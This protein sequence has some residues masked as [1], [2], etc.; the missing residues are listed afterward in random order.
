MNKIQYPQEVLDKM[1]DIVDHCMG[2]APA[3]CV[4]ECPMH[5]DVKSYVKL[6][7]E[8][9]TEEAL[10]VIREKL[11]LPG[12]LGRICAHPCEEKCKRGEQGEAMRIAALKRFA[13]DTCDGPAIWDMKKAPKNG[14]KVAVIGAGPAG[15]QS[16]LDL[17]KKGYE[18]TIYE[19]LP[20][21]GGMMHVGIPE[22]RL[23]RNVINNEYEYLTKLGVEIR[24]GV[25]IGKDISF[26]A[27][28]QS[29]D[30]VIVA[31]GAHIGNVL[32]IEG[33]KA[34]GVL[35]AVDFLREVALTRNY[36]GLGKR[37]VVIGGG[38]VAMD[39][40]RS[41]RRI[42]AEEVILTC[43]EG[44][45]E[46][47]PA[48]LW[49][50]EEAI[51]EG[52]DVRPGY[53]PVKV[54]EEDG[55][56]VGY[57]MKKCLSIFDEKGNF[58]PKYD[59]NDVQV[60]SVDNVCFAIGQG[61]DGSFAPELETQRGGRFVVDQV[62]LQTTKNPKVFVAGDASGRSVIVIEAM[63]EGRKAAESVDRYLNHKNMTEG[64]EE[65]GSYKTWLETE[66]PK[67]E[68]VAKCA[69][70][71]QLDP[72]ERVKSFVEV[73]L[74]LKE[75]DAKAEANRCLQ[76][77]C[78][79][80]MKECTMLNEYCHC[81]KDLFKGILERTEENP[82]VPYSCN[83]C[84]QCTIACPKDYKM[85]A[86]F[87][88]M[89]LKMVQANNGKSPMP[90]H[91]AIDMHQLLG[92]SKPFNTT[93]AAPSG[94][95]KRVFIPGCSL[96]SYAPEAV[97]ALTSYLQEKMPDT[98]VILKC[99]GKP[100]KAVG[101]QGKFKERYAEL[102][103]EIDRLGAEEII[104]ACQSCYLTMSE[105][106]PN[107]KVRSLW[108]ILPEIGLP[109]EAY[110]KAKSS[111]ITFAI[112]DACSTRDISAIHD[113]VRWIMSELGYQTEEPPHARENAMCCGFGGMVVPANPE[114]AQKI[115]NNRTSEIKSDYVVTY[116][117]ACRESMFK[118]GKKSEHLL[119]LI[120]GET[121]TSA[122]PFNGLAAN[123]IESW[124]KRHDSKRQIIKATKQSKR[125]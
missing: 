22:Y 110:G 118:G 123:P 68:V 59:E 12:S 53:G 19:K 32:P 91:K 18:V 67:E 93:Q 24:L 116:C 113:G 69:K 85:P 65:E 70:T 124:K 96:P 49:E 81:P 90:G 51:E 13:A 46:A 60:V 107:Q 94:K 57:E 82:V 4:A 74:G 28:E 48:H 34:T 122:T 14:K 105:Y 33:S 45:H 40:A 95:T 36:E 55:K 31:V 87:M 86:H 63:A 38:N 99:C 58:N 100:T 23:P 47:M 62:T 66:L 102:Q 7:G 9:K 29:N 77:E 41:A 8:G 3:Y 10:K 30:A 89:R 72:A 16:A 109:K 121:K 79:L 26:E 25:E 44:T 115:M 101:Q 92:F 73:D 84:N 37:L 119:Q 83:M 125:K 54:V 64:R 104:V 80:C 103:R 27:L 98:G 52:V 108:E 21:V 17:I 43:L 76:C 111:D 61:V 15:A 78:R 88:Q 106:S 75:V 71:T 39:V 11:F 112:H 35:N 5:T 2:D 56:V 20:V 120:F 117:A 97:G 42:G 1:Q 114:V 50:I 6:I